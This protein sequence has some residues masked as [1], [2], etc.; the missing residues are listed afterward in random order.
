MKEI[1]LILSFG[2]KTCSLALAL[3]IILI[4]SGVAAP[5]RATA[6]YTFLGIWPLLMAV[7]TWLRMRGTSDPRILGRAM[8]HGGWIWASLG[9][10]CVLLIASP[11]FKAGVPVYV[12]IPSTLIGVLLLILGLYTLMWANKRTGVPISM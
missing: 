9:L 12:V 10:G 4:I 11:Y 6:L 7:V 2:K 3:S 1:P 5:L 8:I